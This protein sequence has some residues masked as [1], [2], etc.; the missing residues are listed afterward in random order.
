MAGPQVLSAILIVNLQKENAASVAEEIRR[1][2]ESGG[3]QTTFFAFKGRPDTPPKGQWDIAFSLG[4]DGT[5]LY[6]ARI[7]AHSGTPILPVHL[8]TLGF[9]A[10]VERRKWPEVYKSWIMGKIKPSR[11]CM[12]EFSIE[13][14]G[15]MPLIIVYA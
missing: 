5:V 1:E 15:N 9:I 3:V 2:L 10:G 11:R 13:R 8:G 14:G 6:A 7:L 4:G 12:L